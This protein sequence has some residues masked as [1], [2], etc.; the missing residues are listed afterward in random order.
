MRDVTEDELVQVAREKFRIPD[1]NELRN[2][3]K[4]IL[5][6]LEHPYHCE[7]ADQIMAEMEGRIWDESTLD[8][9]ISK[10]CSQLPL[11]IN[12]GSDS[13]FRKQR[14]SFFT[15]EICAHLIQYMA[16]GESDME[17]GIC[18]TCTSEYKPW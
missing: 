13:P 2:I 5:N 10:L 11:L 1:T 17:P 6:C 9:D 4:V 18:T 8:A 15:F 7:I 16:A 14:M 12:W 3:I